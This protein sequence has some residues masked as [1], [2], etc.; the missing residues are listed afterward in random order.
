MCTQCACDGNGWQRTKHQTCNPVPTRL[1]PARDSPM[2]DLPG[3]NYFSH[4]R[5]ERRQRRL[6]NPW[7]LLPPSPE[8]Y[9]RP[10]ARQESG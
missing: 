8:I 9:P 2:P 10:K 5:L 7:R 4:R 6:V 3:K 1:P